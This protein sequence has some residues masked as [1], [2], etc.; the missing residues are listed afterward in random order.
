[1]ALT[2]TA[3]KALK[4]KTKPYKLFDGGGL[5]LLVTPRGG[6]WWRLEYRL[7]ASWSEFDFDNALWKI[8]S[9][10][11]KMKTPHLVPLSTQA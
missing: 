11:M 4:P 10:R 8:P 5:F 2:D 7:K 1:M 6:K 3:I 9:E